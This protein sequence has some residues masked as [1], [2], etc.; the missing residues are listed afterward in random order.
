MPAHPRRL[1]FALA[2]SILAHAA[3]LAGAPLGPALGELSLFPQDK[4]LRA[5]LAALPD[6]W[7]GVP[8]VRIEPVFP[9]VPPVDIAQAPAEAV[10]RPVGLPAPEIYYHGTDVDVRAEATNSP[11]LEYPEQ[12]LASGTKGTVKLRMKIDYKGAIREV[13]VLEST[14]KGVFDEAALKAARALK[15]KPAIRK[16]VPVG[17]IKQIEVPFDPD[18]MLTGSCIPGSAPPR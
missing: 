12:A 18:C 15:F 8:P 11:D 14:P 7:E 1:A 10:E 4:P 17:S 9:G 6:V 13:E 16:G 2:I 5:R 3:V